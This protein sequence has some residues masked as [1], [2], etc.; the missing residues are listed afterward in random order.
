MQFCPNCDNTFVITRINQDEQQ[1]QEEVKHARQHAR[2]AK[3]DSESNLET[4]TS[5]TDSGEL[6]KLDKLDKIDKIEGG[7][8]INKQ[9]KN[10]DLY[11]FKCINCGYIVPIEE[12]TLIIRRTNEE[13]TGNINE[14]KYADMINDVTL[15]HTRNYICPNKTCISYKAH[16]LRDAIWFKPDRNSYMIKYVCTACKTVW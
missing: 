12:D 14:T 15:P 6:I 13:N 3:D 4:E 11:Y 16:N 5:N 8:N 7:A 10:S 2:T 1:V 9:E